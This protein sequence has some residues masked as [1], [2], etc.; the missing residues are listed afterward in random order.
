MPYIKSRNRPSLDLHREDAAVPLTAGELAYVLAKE[1]NCYLETKAWL[2]IDGKLNFDNLHS[3]VGVLDCLKSEVKR[4]ILFPY[5]DKKI[6]EN[7]DVFT[8]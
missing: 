4:R 8:I 5:E 1:V 7:G 2:N 6:E 3:I